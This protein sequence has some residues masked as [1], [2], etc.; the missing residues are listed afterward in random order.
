MFVELPLSRVISI[1][2]YCSAEDKIIRH[3]VRLEPGTDLP[4]HPP[5]RFSQYIST[6]PIIWPDSH[7]GHVQ[8]ETLQITKPKT[9]N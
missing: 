2:D 7:R 8:D 1:K 6:I 5:P 3:M 4:L 9:A